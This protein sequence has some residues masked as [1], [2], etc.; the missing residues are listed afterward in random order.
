[1][2]GPLRSDR[3]HQP[4]SPVSASGISS[5][6]TVAIGVV[7]GGRDAER[8]RI[9]LGAGATPQRLSVVLQNLAY[10]S[11]S[12][13]PST[14]TR[15]VQV[16]LSDGDGGIAIPHTFGIAVIAV[17]SPPQ[18][19][20]PDAAFAFAEGDAPLAIA[21]AAVLDDADSATFANATLELTSL[22][23][24]HAADRWRIVADAVVGTSGASVLHGGRIIGTWSGGDGATPLRVVFAAT[25][26]PVIA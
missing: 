7:S 18:L 9:A 16:R 20:L 4:I 15:S 12:V 26:T 21:S 1:M 3:I 6:G 17:N 2:G 10:W 25:A 19:A 13:A 5:R 11:A 8:L 22:G 23:I 24:T 14:A